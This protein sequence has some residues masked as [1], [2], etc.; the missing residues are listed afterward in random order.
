M[1]VTAIHRDDGL[2]VFLTLSHQD[3]D[4]LRADYARDVPGADL[5]QI[6]V[7]DVARIVVTASTTDEQTL[8]DIERAST[9]PV[10]V[11]TRSEP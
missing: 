9:V 5:R 8:A 1:I 3:L 11:F 4:M 2:T 10:Q 6:G 7:H